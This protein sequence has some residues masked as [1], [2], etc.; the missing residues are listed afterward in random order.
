MSDA[1]DISSTRLRGRLTHLHRSIAAATRVCNFD[2]RVPEQAV[3]C[4]VI[5][6]PGITFSYVRNVILRDLYEGYF[7][8]ISARMP[9]RR[10]NSCGGVNLYRIFSLAEIYRRGLWQTQ[11]DA[12]C[13]TAFSNDFFSIEI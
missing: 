3:T 9:E 4:Y 8:A 6:G 5:N 10:D 13:N 12:C 7:G 1:A 11:S 2:G